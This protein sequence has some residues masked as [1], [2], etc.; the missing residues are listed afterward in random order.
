MIN[1]D[2]TINAYKAKECATTCDA[3][4]ETN[5]ASSSCEFNYGS[6]CKG[7][8]KSDAKL[9]DTNRVKYIKKIC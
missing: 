3:Y 5:M 9:G 2:G 1:K 8:D 4:Y 6:Y 7:E